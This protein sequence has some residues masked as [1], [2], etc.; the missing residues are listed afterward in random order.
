M[1]NKIFILLISVYFVAIEA[2]HH[3]HDE[4]HVHATPFKGL[5][6]RRIL[7][8][9]YPIKKASVGDSNDLFA[10]F[11][12]FE[13]R[14]T[15]NPNNEFVLDYNLRFYH[16]T[17]RNLTNA[18]GFLT[19]DPH[20]IAKMNLYIMNTVIEGTVVATDYTSWF[21]VQGTATS[22]STGKSETNYYIL[23]RSQS[24]EPNV[25]STIEKFINLPARSFTAYSYKNCPR[26]V[27]VTPPRAGVMAFENT[28]LPV[29][30]PRCPVS[31]MS[32]CMY[33]DCTN[34]GCSDGKICCPKSCGGTWCR[35]P[36]E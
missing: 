4:N 35:N 34:D 6:T 5:D 2:S 26:P 14:F 12:C 19:L 16:K 23:S 33:E 15:Q 24:L 1:C 13:E 7:G 28:I 27:Q 29:P 25:L 18:H 17:A 31:E 36:V 20:E 22:K 3:H 32:D 30:D 9:W 21:V 10:D 8:T 11:D